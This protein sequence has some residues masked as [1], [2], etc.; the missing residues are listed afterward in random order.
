MLMQFKTIVSIKYKRLKSTNRQ[1]LSANRPDQDI[2][3][4]GF[5]ASAAKI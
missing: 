1:L 4:T 3:L 2:L 5:N